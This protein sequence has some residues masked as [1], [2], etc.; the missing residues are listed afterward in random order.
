M[1]ITPVFDSHHSIGSGC[2]LT[3]EEPG[4]AK[5]GNPISV[6]DLAT[7]GNLKEVVLCSERI[8]GFMQAYK[9]AI[10]LGIKLCPGIKVVIAPDMTI[11]DDASCRAESKVAIMALNTQGYHD[12]LRIYSRAW[13]DGFYYVGRADWNLLR[14]LWTPNLGLALPFFSSFIAKNTLT[15]AQIVPDL[16]AIPWVFREVGSQL[17]FAP[18]IDAAIDRYLDGTGEMARAQVVPVKSV[19]Y[20]KRADLKPYTVMRVL[21]KHDKRASYDAPGVDHLASAEFCWE[22]FCELQ[23][24]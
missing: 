6:F 18:L 4:K 10:K 24:R 8:D 15:R 21:D 7:Q 16:P 19:Y 12:L 5:P 2:L 11:K 14:E 3:L 23:R 22:S 20:A 13:T 17:P 1:T 9:T